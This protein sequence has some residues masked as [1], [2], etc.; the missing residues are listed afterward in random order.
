[1]AFGHMQPHY[2]RLFDISA[3]SLRQNVFAITDGPHFDCKLSG[4]SAKRDAGESLQKASAVICRLQR[5][6]SPRCPLRNRQ[7]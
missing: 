4:A 7:R 2:N 3:T 6:P 1:M 5:F